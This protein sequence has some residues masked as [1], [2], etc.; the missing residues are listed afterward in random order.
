MSEPTDSELIDAAALSVV[1]VTKRLHER[2]ILIN[3][4]M[5]HLAV[6]TGRAEVGDAETEPSSIDE[7]MT[8]ALEMIGAHHRSNPIAWTP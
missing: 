5:Y 2:T 4:I 1:A 7:L 8:D 3:Q 6:A